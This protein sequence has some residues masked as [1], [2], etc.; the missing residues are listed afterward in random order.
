M[1]EN[2]KH[3]CHIHPKDFMGKRERIIEENSED[4]GQI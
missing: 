3:D 2:W 4:V 1:T